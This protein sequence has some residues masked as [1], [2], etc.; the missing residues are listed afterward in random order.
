MS[1][2]SHNDKVK[3]FTRLRELFT[4]GNKAIGNKGSA[5][6]LTKIKR[7]QR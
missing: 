7:E 2:W 6:F 5:Y 1:G 3:K 4:A